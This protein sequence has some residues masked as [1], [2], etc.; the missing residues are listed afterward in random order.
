MPRG[1]GWSYGGGHFLEGEVPHVEDTL[2]S[3]TTIPARAETKPHA[4][5]TEDMVRAYMDI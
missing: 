5:A 1:L 2:R 3:L 4:N